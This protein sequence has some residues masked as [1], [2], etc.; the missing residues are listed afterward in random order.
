[1]KILI[2]N[3]GSSSLKFALF[4]GEKK[5]K[6]RLITKG[7]VE[8]IGIDNSF[9]VVNV[10]GEKI[11][12]DIAFN[13]HKQAVDKLIE[14]LK[15]DLIKEVQDERDIDVIG[16][17]VVHGL[18]FLTPIEVRQNKKEV[19]E[20]AKNLTKAHYDGLV[21]TVE[22]FDNLPVSIKQYFDFDTIFHT[23]TMNEETYT[24]ALPLELCEKYKI[25]KY[26][27]HGLSNQYIARRMKEINKKNKVII[28]CHLGS[29]SSI[30]AIIDGKSYD[31]SMGYTPVA[32]VVM[33]TRCGDIDP[34]IV[35]K[36]MSDDS[37]AE[38]VDEIMN[39]KSGLY[40]ICGLS[41]FRD[42]EE[43]AKKGNKK[44]K[45]A[46]NVAIDSYAK[47]IGKM[48]ATVGDKIKPDLTNLDIVFTGG[49]GENSAFVREAIF[50]KLHYLGIKI[51]KKLNERTNRSPET[52][53]STKTS[54]VN[55]WV[56]P[57]FEELSICYNLFDL[58]S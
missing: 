39:L 2:V 11:K 24:Y 23:K 25:R 45:L 16:F 28:C 56:I 35:T 14:I 43:R 54:K 48:I 12:F 8:R 55:V 50:K 37:G 53:V 4:E 58:L 9:I 29:G 44:C 1:M 32:G 10:N 57:T 34:S 7:V 5:R 30:T 47:E 3:P 36:L 31:N 42:I 38:Q 18:D 21:K 6:L 49:I 15:S 41:D 40:G 19:Y 26:G 27:A 46:L 51:D 13:N 22:A 52:L 20:I 33:A 17:R